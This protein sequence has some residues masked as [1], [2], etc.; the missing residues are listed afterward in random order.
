[1]KVSRELGELMGEFGVGYLFSW[2]DYF[3]GRD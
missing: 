2:K 1:M 3:E